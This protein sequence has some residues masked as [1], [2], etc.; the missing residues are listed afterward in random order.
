MK[1]FT[2]IMFLL[3]AISIEA[4][5]QLPVRKF[6]N[7]KGEL[8]ELMSSDPGDEFGGLYGFYNHNKRQWIIKPQYERF[9]GFYYGYCVAIDKHRNNC[10]RVACWEGFCVPLRIE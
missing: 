7:S 10:D 8:V 5:S 6:K 4:V 1:K 9:D 3:L 2:F